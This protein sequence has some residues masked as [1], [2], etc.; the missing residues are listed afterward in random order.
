[1][2]HEKEGKN[3][4]KYTR[5]RLQLPVDWGWTDRFEFTDRITS[6]GVGGCFLQTDK[7]APRDTPIFVRLWLSPTDNRW[8]P[9]KVAYH[10]EK[11]GM[12]VEF[13]PLAAEDADHVQDIVDFYREI[14]P[15]G[16]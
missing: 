4:R 5:G 15:E 16:S 8:I 1:M 14:N 3:R 7:G 9:G 6:L 11:V 13:D 2:E 12:G 10:L